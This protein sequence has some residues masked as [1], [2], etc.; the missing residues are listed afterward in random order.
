LAAL[1]KEA[2][3]FMRRVLGGGKA[4]GEDADLFRPGTLMTERMDALLARLA[5][6]TPEREAARIHD[7]NKKLTVYVPPAQKKIRCLIVMESIFPAAQKDI[8]KGSFKK[9]M[10]GKGYTEKVVGFTPRDPGDWIQELAAEI[11]KRKE[12]YQ[13]QYKGDGRAEDVEVEFDVACLSTAEVEAIQ[14]DMPGVSALAFAPA[15]AGIDVNG[16]QVEGIVLALRAL[17]K[18]D[19]NILQSI[20]K[21]LGGADIPPEKLSKIKNISDFARLV[22]F[23]LPVIRVDVNRMPAVNRL[24]RDNI[25][26]AA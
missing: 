19:M 12:A 14:K 22:T 4:G 13:E 11:E 23:S 9:E 1:D 16:V 3:D 20:Y 15:E 10:D 5:G 2:D 18:N 26:S 7:E 17:R 25:S 24:I 21:F 8:L 6:M